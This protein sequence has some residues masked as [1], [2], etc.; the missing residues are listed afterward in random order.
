MRR[1]DRRLAP[2]TAADYLSGRPRAAPRRRACTW[3]GRTYSSPV[4]ALT[5]VECEAGPLVVEF[6]HRATTVKWAVRLQVGRFPSST[7]R[8]APCRDHHGLARRVLRRLRAPLSLSRPPEALVRALP[9]PGRRLQD[10]AQ[11][12]ARRDPLVRGRRP[13]DPAAPAPDR[14]AGRG[15]PPGHPDPVPPGGRQGRQPGRVR[16]RA[17]QEAL[18]AGPRA[19]DRRG[20]PAVDARR[21]R[22]AR[23]ARHID[24]SKSAHDLRPCSRESIPCIT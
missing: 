16:R 6:P 11:D 13:G 21:T 5:V 2:P 10:P 19:Q 24:K 14:L 4:G 9:G 7:S 3:S 1:R 23:E 18:A 15:Q 8:R 22:P 12:P 20:G 17:G